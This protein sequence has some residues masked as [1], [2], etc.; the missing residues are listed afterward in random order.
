MLTWCLVDYSR[1]VHG[2]V[3]IA[4]EEIPHDSASSPALSP[5]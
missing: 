2:G 5:Y 4:K 3:Q 1:G